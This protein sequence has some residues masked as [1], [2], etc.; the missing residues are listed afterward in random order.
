MKQIGIA[1]AP[2][3]FDESGSPVCAPFGTPYLPHNNALGAATHFAGALSRS[4]RF[5]L[6]IDTFCVL[7]V[8]F[9]LGANFLETAARW[10]RI[11]ENKVSGRLDYVALE[12]APLS[13]DDFVHAS[14]ASGLTKLFNSHGAILADRWPTLLRGAHRIQFSD[15]ITLT[16]IFDDAAAYLPTLQC[17]ADVIF[18]DAHSP[19]VNP[20]LWAA[21]VMRSLAALA[22]PGCQLVSCNASASACDALSEVGFEPQH[23][24]GAS[25]DWDGCYARFMPRY[26]PR[27]SPESHKHWSD[28]TA[29]VVGGGIAGMTCAQQLV[30]TGWQVTLIDKKAELSASPQQQPALAAHLHFSADDNPMARLTR[31]ACQL[32]TP[33]HSR[34]R[35]VGRIALETDAHL[36]ALARALKDCPPEFAQPVSAAEASDIAGIALSSA[37]LWLPGLPVRY[38]ADQPSPNALM[39]NHDI[40]WTS[41]EIVGLRRLDDLWACVDINEGVIARASI[42][43]LATGQLPLALAAGNWPGVIQHFG[44]S[45]TVRTKPPQIQCVIG[46][47]GYAC[48]LLESDLILAGATSIEPGKS[49]DRINIDEQNIAQ[50]A[51]LTNAARAELTPISS[52][53]GTRYTTRDHLPLIGPMSDVAAITANAERLGRN[54]RLPLPEMDGVY[55]ATGFGSRG[56]LWST[57][58]AQCITDHVNNRSAVLPA[59]LTRAIAPNRFLR[60]LLRKGHLKQP[61]VTQPPA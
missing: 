14:Q 22:R 44:Q 18:F 8:G 51:A 26:K 48:P 16:L 7:E 37:G 9:G 13:R 54:D 40:Q 60:R 30:A 23:V 1:P 28:R 58:A 34:L 42:V 27:S 2:L 31:A 57:L 21:P 49:A 55:L 53:A 24:S 20:L 61:L 50:L 41:G 15:Q 10:Q 36:D 19:Q 17:A 6:D 5:G 35:P 11:S 12:I 43:V 4:E 52:H 29:I 25:G 33:S 32:M 38:S 39:A 45:T 3:H 47:A 59:D 46:G 56:L